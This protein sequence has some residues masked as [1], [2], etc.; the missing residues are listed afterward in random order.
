MVQV[1]LDAGADPDKTNYHRDTSLHMAAHNGD[2]DIAK[3]LLDG[4][5]KIEMADKNG[6]TPL[7]IAL[8]EGHEG[9]LKL[10]MEYSPTNHE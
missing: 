3:M 4:G 7:Q 9:A 2:L 6:F 1:L 10:F 5:A 8:W